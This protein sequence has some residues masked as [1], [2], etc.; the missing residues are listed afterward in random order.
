MGAIL[1]GR[2]Q[3]HSVL[4]RGGMGKVYRA[5]DRE[6]GQIVALKV[7]SASPDGVDWIGR[8]QR[9]GEALR[10]LN[11]PHI[12][13]M[14]HQFEEHGRHYLVLECV[15]GGSLSE[16]PGLPV[17]RVV[18]IFL[19]LADALTRAH[20]LGIIH[21]DLKPDNVL[22]AED[23]SVRLTDFGMASLRGAAPLTAKGA[24]LG[25]LPYMSPQGFM[26][27]APSPSY[28]IWA[29]GVMLFEILGGEKP[30]KGET[31]TDLIHSIFGEQAPDLARLRPDLPA[32]LVQLTASMLQKE[33]EQRIPSMRQVGVELAEILASIVQEDAESF[34]LRE[35]AVVE[36]VT[37][38]L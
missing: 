32:A 26:G 8:F 24:V 23:G 12:V 22:L 20:Q 2:Y 14:L 19:D 38:D 4:G 18:E 29:L 11:H 15:S 5:T 6:N 7:L 25:T 37:P 31:L 3:T 10:R 16:L 28:D 35:G 21:R 9:E 36:S 33:P 27:D 13:K 34:T 17:K 1:G 30:F